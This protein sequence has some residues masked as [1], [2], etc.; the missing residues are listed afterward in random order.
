M[1]ACPPRSARGGGGGAQELEAR[2]QRRWGLTAGEDRGTWPEKT[3][4]RGGA[5]A[6]GAQQR[7]QTEKMRGLRRVRLILGAMGR[8][9]FYSDGVLVPNGG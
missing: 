4:A 9:T 7:R 1:T 5:R 8:Q 2:G 6:R 3:G